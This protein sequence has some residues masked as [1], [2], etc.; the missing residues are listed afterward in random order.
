MT[1][2]PPPPPIQFLEQ[3]A[4]MLQMETQDSLLSSFYNLATL[5]SFIDTRSLPMGYMFDNQPDDKAS[6]DMANCEGAD[7]ILRMACGH[8]AHKGC[9]RN[10]MCDLCHTPL[11]TKV[12]TLCKS[13]NANL[14]ADTIQRSK[15]QSSEFQ[16]FINEQVN[17]KQ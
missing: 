13:W 7:S 16:Q 4:Y 6:C 14:L 9:L 10:K 17:E 15:S 11:M 5:D 2:P 8:T 3:Y 1:P 12:A